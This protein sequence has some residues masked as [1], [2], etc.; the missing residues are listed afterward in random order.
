MLS[1]ALLA[2]LVSAVSVHGASWDPSRHAW[3]TSDSANDWHNALPIG[4][5]RLGALA[6]GSSA[7]KLTLNENSVWSGPWQDRVNPRAK[8]ALADIW[9]NLVA[10]QITAA[11]NSA[12]ANLAGDPTSPKAYNPTVDLNIDF[13]HG[14]LSS[15]SNYTRWLDT[16]EGTSGVSYVKNGVTY[17]FVCP[18]ESSRDR[19]APAAAADKNMTVANTSPAILMEFSPSA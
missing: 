16:I 8:N 7:E 11:G 12:M 17:K 4:N 1:T 14:A 6:F 5:G 9:K 15:L 3:Y 10:G 2:A 19:L 13:G 18:S